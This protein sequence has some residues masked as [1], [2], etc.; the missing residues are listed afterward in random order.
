MKK[1]LAILLL[2]TMLLPLIVA[3]KAD[4]DDKGAIIP[5]YFAGPVENLDPTAA[6]YDKDF[7]QSSGLI[8]ESLTSVVDGKLRNN[9]IESWEKKYDEERG[10]YTL[11]I[12]LVST[13]WNDGRVL[14]ADQIVFAWKRALSPEINSPA[15]SLLY[16]LKNARDIKAGI[17]TIDDLGAAALNTTTLEVQFEKP[18]EPELFLEAIASPALVPLRD[19]VV[20][21]VETL[22]G[23]TYNRE[24]VWATTT[25]LIASNGQFMMKRMDP[26][27]SYRFEFSKFYKLKSEAKNLNEYVKPCRLISDYD[28]SAEEALASFDS[29]DIYYFNAITP[30]IYEE[31]SKDIKSFDTIAS[32]TYYY[33]CK[34]EVLAD[35]RV[36]QAL[37]V[38]LDRTAIAGLVGMGSVA[39]KGF[40]PEKAT[41]SA[42]NGSFRKEAG[43]VYAATAETEKAQSLLSEAG[44]RSGSFTLTYRKDRSYEEAVAQYAKTPWEAL[45]FSVKLN[46]VSSEELVTR[47]AESDFDV[48]GLDF[49][50]L[51]TNP[52]AFLAPFAPSF[53]GAVVSVDPADEGESLHPTGFV[54]EEYEAMLDE[55]LASTDR[56]TRTQKLILL[57]QLFNTASPATALVTYKNN[58][59]ASKELSGLSGNLFGYTEFTKATLKD[60][61]NK[62]E[63]YEQKEK[64]AG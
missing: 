20:T 23:T 9:L 55:I 32:Y 53:S 4:P 7:Y 22:N 17:K 28:Q 34:N 49:I 16:D 26:R 27:G 14:T 31:R 64:A 56:K 51:S 19:D 10:E 3:C 25:D 5:V 48:I 54:S 21:G 35:A 62:N 13:K 39:A 61:K 33:N 45:G 36:R 11:S 15:A 42:L 37:S 12:K 29:G 38:S 6:I 30:E 46:G 41:G 2:V 24:E 59:L 1:T 60:Y 50:G 57:E 40:V 63:A 52:Y 18:I 44:V 43:A 8:F 47:I 58:Y